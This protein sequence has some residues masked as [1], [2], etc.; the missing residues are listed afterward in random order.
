M[1][2]DSRAQIIAAARQN[3][4]AAV[5]APPALA[6][7]VQYDDIT[8]QFCA[9]VEAIG[10]ETV[11]VRSPAEANHEL[12]TRRPLAPGQQSLSD[13]EGLGT[14]TV[15]PELLA[16]PHALDAL[17]V[18]IARGLVGVAENGAIWVVQTNQFARAALF[19]CQ[20]LVLVVA[21][22]DLVHNLHEGYQQIAER[23]L[24]PRDGFAAWVAGPSK[25]AD[26]EQSLVIGAQGPRTL[27][28][29]VEA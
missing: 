14:T 8:Q 24:Y 4:P 28:V 13:V 26:I 7:A 20:H 5:P 10:G 16:D 17:E 19:L 23:N 21:A 22:A 18:A 15:P 3:A 9:M 6:G 25:T 29:I 2:A 12:T 1:M 11:V 27:L